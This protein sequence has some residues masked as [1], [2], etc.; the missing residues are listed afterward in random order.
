M[1]KR[2]FLNS[3]FFKRRRLVVI[4][5][6]AGRCRL[7]ICNTTTKPG[8]HLVSSARTIRGTRRHVQDD[9][10]DTTTVIYLKFARPLAARRRSDGGVVISH[11]CTN[12]STVKIGKYL[13]LSFFERLTTMLCQCAK[14]SSSEAGAVR[15]LER[16]SVGGRVGRGAAA[17]EAPLFT[18]RRS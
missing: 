11:P 2:C 16:V 1:V 14:L 8:S 10:N 4:F 6:A 5:M 13:V 7:C 9:L 3:G 17:T 15:Q 12:I 18:R